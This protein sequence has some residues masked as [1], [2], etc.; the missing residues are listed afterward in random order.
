MGY[1]PASLELHVF[2]PDEDGETLSILHED[3][4]ETFAFRDGAFYRTEFA[5]RARR[6]RVTL[7]ATVTGEGY[8][9]FAP[10][11]TRVAFPRS[12]G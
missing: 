8:P 3:D 4:G 1:H 12:G 6:P 2:L 10:P 11:G 5:L 7:E 9:A